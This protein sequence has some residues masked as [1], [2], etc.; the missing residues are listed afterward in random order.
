VP[1][2]ESAVIGEALTLYQ[3]ELRKPSLT[4][5]VLDTSGSMQGQPL[6]ELKTAMGLLLDPDASAVNLLQPSSRD[7]TIILPF[8]SRAGRPLEVTG[9]EP[10]E[11]QRAETYVARLQAD[12]GTDL[13]GAIMVALTQ[14]KP[15]ADEGTLFEY[16]P[17]IVAMTDGASNTDN[18]RKMLNALRQSG[19]GLDV[20]IHSIAFGNADTAQ[21]EELSN[22]TVGRM[23]TAGDDLAKALRSAKGYN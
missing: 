5:W 2:P 11:L 18:R 23:F 19:F 8:S 6:A 16:L 1:A 7:V 13:Y 22:A 17:A 12:G 3:T 4:V 20:P 9:A 10:G 14:L 15:Y 21:L